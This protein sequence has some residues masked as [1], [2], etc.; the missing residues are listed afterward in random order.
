[1]ISVLNRVAAFHFSLLGT[2]EKVLLEEVEPSEY[3]EGFTRHYQR[4]RFKLKHK[5]AGLR[6]KLVPVLL[7]KVEDGLI[8]GRQNESI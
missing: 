2:T 1:M 3:G 7:E 6:G 8:Y 5:G 4:V